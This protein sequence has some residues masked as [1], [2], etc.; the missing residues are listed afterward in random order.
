M[1]KDSVLSDPD[2][3]ALG[4]YDADLLPAR[5]ILG[6]VLDQKQKYHL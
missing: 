1:T 2:L 4:G 3:L 5:M 6:N